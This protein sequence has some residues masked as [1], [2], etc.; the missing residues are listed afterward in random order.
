M[1]LNL[2]HKIKDYKTHH[3]NR[4]VH[5]AYTYGFLGNFPNVVSDAN[6]LRV[7]FQ[8]LFRGSGIDILD[9]QGVF[10]GELSSQVARHRVA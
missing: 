10:G 3:G 8:E 9:E 4:E 7:L 5:G 1:T 2:D 6:T